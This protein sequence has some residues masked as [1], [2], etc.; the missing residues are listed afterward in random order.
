MNKFHT[1]HPKVGTEWLTTRQ[2]AAYC[3]C[4]EKSIER[5]VGRKKLRS[6]RLL[7]SRQFRFRRAWLDAWMLGDPPD[8]GTGTPSAEQARNSESGPGRF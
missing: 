2:A 8:T 1:V 7:S 3:S 5:A 4:S 6:V